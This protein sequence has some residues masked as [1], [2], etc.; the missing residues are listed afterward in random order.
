METGFTGFC[1]SIKVQHKFSAKNDPNSN[2]ADI[3]QYFSDYKLKT[4]PSKT[5]AAAF[6]AVQILMKDFTVS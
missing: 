3:D 4:H 1:L 2:R 6:L 5:V